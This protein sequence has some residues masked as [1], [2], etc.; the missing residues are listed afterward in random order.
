MQ[1]EFQ[2]QVFS[3]PTSYVQL[4]RFPHLHLVVQCLGYTVDVRDRGLPISVLNDGQVALPDLQHVGVASVRGSRVGRPRSQVQ[5]GRDEAVDRVAR[6]AV[7]VEGVGKVDAATTMS[8]DIQDGS[9]MTYKY[10][11]NCL[12]TAISAGAVLG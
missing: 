1:S 5:S 6:V 10:P 7:G 3:F 9:R 8:V 4:H 2:N 12:E 11:T